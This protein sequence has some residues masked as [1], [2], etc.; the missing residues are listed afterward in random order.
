[1]CCT[2]P[3]SSRRLAWSAAYSRTML[4][5]MHQGAQ[6][7]GSSCSRLCRPLLLQSLPLRRHDWPAR[8]EES[9]AGRQACKTPSSASSCR[10]AISLQKNKSTLNSSLATSRDD[11]DGAP[12]SPHGGGASSCRPPRVG[13]FTPAL[14]LA[15]DDG[16]PPNPSPKQRRR[17]KPAASTRALHHSRPLPLPFA[18]PKYTRDGSCGARKACSSATERGPPPPPPSISSRPPPP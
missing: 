7:G 13:P 3:L 9:R 17:P 14:S 5:R 18:H 2:R 1:V 4:W 10:G 16:A 12:P 11:D 8:C 15:D 6:E